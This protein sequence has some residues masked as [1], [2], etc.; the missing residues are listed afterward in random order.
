[1][2]EE[3]TAERLAP[4]ISHRTCFST[5]VCIV[6]CDCSVFHDQ[7]AAPYTLKKVSYRTKGYTQQ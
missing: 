2:A 5:N 1:M 3:M 4:Q 6:R 7:L